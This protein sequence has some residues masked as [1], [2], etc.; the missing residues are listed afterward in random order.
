MI[1]TTLIILAAAAGSGS[2]AALVYWGMVA[3]RVV[4][5]NGQ[6]CQAIN[7]VLAIGTEK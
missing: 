2:L 4:V 3:V 6:L 7:V 1:E 5:H